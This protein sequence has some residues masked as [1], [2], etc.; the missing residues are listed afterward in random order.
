MARNPTNAPKL[1]KDRLPVLPAEKP[2]AKNRDLA[3]LVGL[4]GSDRILLKRLLKEL[5]AEGAI[6]GKAKRGFT[7]QGDLP[8]V[9]LLEIS[10]IDSDG[11][12]LG[13]PLNWESN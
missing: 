1:D 12:L 3:R 13:R 7:K 10:G 9:T 8:D 5:E 6:A 11:E 4:K 2:G